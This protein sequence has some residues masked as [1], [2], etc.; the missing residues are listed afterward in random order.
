MDIDLEWYRTFHAVGRCGSISQAAQALSV[1][2]PAVSQI[3]RQLE[4]RTG[5]QLFMR[6]PKGATLTPEG[7]ALY[8]Y[9]DQALGLLATAQSQ[10]EGQR[11]LTS[12]KLRIG[13]SDTLCKHWL[14]KH[15]ER[16]HRAHPGIDIQVTNRTSSETMELLKRGEA[17]LGLINLPMSLPARFVTQEIAH[18]HDCFVYSPTAFPELGGVCAWARLADLPLIMLENASAT[19]RAINAAAE[20]HGIRLAP[21]IEL[22]SLDLLAE[23]AI[24]GLGVASVVE[25]FIAPQLASGQLRK[26]EL[27]PPAPPRAIALVRHADLPLPHSA[28]AFLTEIEPF[29]P[30]RKG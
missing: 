25:E 18:V 21:E 1:S 30:V 3:I 20:A 29:L 17:D 4:R 16:F 2:Q 7:E 23:F 27:T 5:S 9:V 11:Q 6:N 12:G 28:R 10:L 19:R 26:L 15:L 24:S 22:G 13:A 8:R 14:L